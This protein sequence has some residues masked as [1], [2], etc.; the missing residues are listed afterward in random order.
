M[1]CA[2]LRPTVALIIAALLFMTSCDDSGDPAGLNGT[3]QD[4]LFSLSPYGLTLK[5]GESVTI[6]PTLTTVKGKPVNPRSLRW[7]SS[8]AGTAEVSR[9]GV[10]TAV[11]AGEVLIVA[12]SGN[13]AD[14]TRVRVLADSVSRHGV[15]IAPDTVLLT[16][17]DATALLTAAVYE[18]NGTPHA[19][20]GLTWKSLNPGVAQVDNMGTITAKGAGLALIVAT[21][22]CCNQSD[23]A[24]ARVQQVIDSVSIDPRTARLGVDA[25]QQLTARA[26]DR[27]RSLIASAT[28]TWTSDNSGVAKVSSGGQV[29]AVAAGKTSIRAKS[30]SLTGVSSVT[31]GT[32]GNVAELPRVWVNT[33]WVEP[34]G[35][36]IVVPAGGN[37]QA[38]IDGAS[39]GDVIELQRGATYGSI[40]LP[41]K[42]GSGWVVIR[43]SGTLPAAGTRMTPA[44]GSGLAKIVS[45][46]GATRPVATASG[47]SHYRI[48]GVEL[49]YA[50]SV[51]QANAVVT[52][53]SSSSYIILDRVYAH[54][55]SKLDLQRCVL[56]HAAH[57]AVIDSWLSECH[58]KGADSQAIVAWDTPGPLKIVNN[59]LAGAGENIM[60]G[61]S[62]SNNGTPSDIEIRRN[63]FYKPDTW[64][65]T[66]TNPRTVKN[67]FEIKFAARVL[68]EGNVFDGN[69]SDA[70]DGHA[71]NIKLSAYGEGDRCEDIT[72]RN[73]IIRRSE[74][75]LKIV[76]PAN[77]VV[78]QNNLILLDGERAFT[79][80]YAHRDVQLLNNTIRHKGNIIT[81]QTKVDESGVRRTAQGFVATGNIWG[82]PS[83]YGVKGG[84]G[85]G[86]ATL[87]GDFGKDEWIYQANGHIGR[88]AAYYPEGNLFVA[89]LAEVRFDSQWRVPA[90]S[91]FA[92]LGVDMDALLA[93]TSGVVIK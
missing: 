40:T 37:L 38:A 55:H 1:R 85:E 18:A 76:S 7:A 66:G 29:T 45:T 59:H 46:S 20:P 60:L 53:G 10:V 27:G 24:Y 54:G 32:A 86:T 68:L 71:F 78:V 2:M 33:D 73:N 80:L 50:P 63:H 51:T 89:T 65:P 13:V 30:G 42:S 19:A 87:N 91:P 26:W 93:A 5:V 56:L 58:Y 12:A 41:A 28:F 92:G 75:G 16:W 90:S 39:R 4:V 11:A 57:G 62:T 64:R 44:T 61:G 74:R 23:T 9:D 35:K 15:A 36:T 88:N 47:A 72:I 43:S 79:L 48:V 14:T 31:V 25:T 34:T 81:S 8:A 6:T 67:L 69:W 3:S 52:L 49:T 77:R 70:Q 82:D 84:G 83:G 17:L 22:T 21:A